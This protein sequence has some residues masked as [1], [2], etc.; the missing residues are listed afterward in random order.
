M[1]KSINFLIDWLIIFRH[2]YYAPLMFLP[3]LIWTIGNA[4]YHPCP[5]RRLQIYNFLNINLSHY[6]KS[7]PARC[8]Y[9]SRF[10]RGP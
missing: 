5:N 6:P 10:I 2:Y 3:L 9:R 7:G 1:K 4:M 8:T